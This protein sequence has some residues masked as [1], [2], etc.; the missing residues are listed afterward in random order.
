MKR[1]S[2]L[3]MLL[4]A[5]CVPLAMNAQTKSLKK[6]AKGLPKFEV[7][8]PAKAMPSNPM[9]SKLESAKEAAL[10]ELNGRGVRADNELLTEGF[11]N[12]SSISTTYSA[13]G[14]YAYNAGSGNNWTLNSTSTYANNGSKSAQV[15]YSSSYA[16]NCYLVSAPF[17]VSS[18]M[19]EL[20]VSL[21]ERVR[22]ASYAEI[23]EVFFV[24]ANDVTSAAGVASATKYNAIASASYTNTTYAQQSGTVTNSALAGQS[25]RVVVHCTSEADKY[26]LYIDDITVTEKTVVE[27]CS[28]PT[29]FAATNV[30]TNSVTLSWT[31]TGTSDTWV[32]YYM[33]E[34]DETTS[35]EIAE[36]NPFTLTG[37]NPVTN[38]YALV[39][40][41]CGDL[42]Q[43]SDVIEFTTQDLPCSKPTDL[44]VTA[45]TPSSATVSWSGE[46]DSYTI[47]YRVPS[48]FRYD[49]ESATAF[50]V[51]DFSPCTTYDG[52]GYGTYTIQN[53]TFDN[54][55]YTGSF[56]N[57]Q[58]G[59][60]SGLSA[61]GGNS[62]G[63]CFAAT[64]A[65]NNDWFILPAITI[66][67]GDVFSF[68]AKEYTDSYPEAFKVG[69]YRGN[70]AFS[71]Y[72]AGS[73]SS[74]ITPTTTWT[75]YSYDLSA[76][77]GQTIQLAIQCVSNDAFIFCID[78]IFVG[79]PNGNDSW[80]V[81]LTDVS[82]PYTITGLQAETTYEWHVQGD[83]GADG[84]SL[85]SAI[86]TFTTPNACG[87]PSGLTTTDITGT[88]ATLSWAAALDE[89]NVT[90]TKGFVYDF[91][92]A[93]PWVVDSFDPCTTYDGD[94]TQ[95]YG[96]EDADVTNIPFTGACVAFQNGVSSNLAAHSG[97]AFGMMISPAS[98]TV[99]ANDWFILPEIAIE[100]GDVFSFWGREITTQ[101]GNEV[102][103]VGVYGSQG[104]FSSYLA[105]NVQVASTDWTEY[106]Y[107]LS[108]YAGQTIQLA[109]NYV[110]L[111]IFGFMFDDIFVGNPNWSTPVSVT[112]STYTLEGLSMNTNYVW[113]V[114]GVDC[115]GNGSTT[116]WSSASFTTLDGILVESITADDV[117]V[118]VD[119][120][121]SIT[122]LVVLP[123]DATNPAVTYTSN[124]ETIAT[125]ENGVVTGVAVGTTTITIAA[126]DGSGVTA[127]INVTVNGIDVTGITAENVTVVNGETATISYTV[128][129]TNATDASVTFTSANTAIATVDADGVVTGVSVGETTITITSVSNPEVTAEITVTVTSNPNAVQF[130]VNAPANAAPGDVITV[131]AVLN[132][133]TEGTYNGF[134]GLVLGLHFNT[135]AFAVYGNPVPGPVASASTLTMPSLPNEN[136]ETVNYSC[137]MTS[138]NPNTTTGLVFSMQFTVL[139]EVESGSYTFYVEP[140]AA[141]QFVYNP[142]SGA[143][144]IPYEYVPST[145][146]I[147][148][149]EQYTL[150]IT[151][152]TNNGG[153]Y[154]IASPIGT[155]NPTEV[156]NM[157]TPNDSDNNRTYDLYRF[158]QDPSDGLE[159]RNYRQGVFDLEVGKGYLYAHRTD[160]DLVFTG[161]AISESTYEVPLTKVAASAGLEFPDWNLVG[162]PFAE[163]AHI[164]EGHPFYTLDVSGAYTLVSDGSQT[165]ES[166]QGVFVVAGENEDH[167]TFVKGEPSAKSP[168]VTLNV[169]NGTE[170]G[171]IDR[172]IVCF[173]ETRQMPKFQF[174][175]NSTKVYIPM[176]GKEY[177][178][179]RG[180]EM[181]ELPVNFKA[182]SNGTYSLNFSSE[183]VEFAYLHLIDNKTGNDVDL[184][185][186]PSYSFE[187]KTTD[188]ESRFKL[189]FATGDNS[190]DDNFAFFSNGSFVINNEGEAEL[191]VIDVMGRIL[192]SETIN[193][194]TNVNVNGA[195]GVYMLRLINGDN[196]KVQKVVVK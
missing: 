115:D 160:V 103:N 192:S 17:T 82:S 177:A 183:I 101:Y 43:D 158:Q 181:G 31:E 39:T 145:V 32:I 61:H 45:M 178:L 127:T 144:P 99:S 30:T 10:E 139:T 168:K 116:D 170:S 154:L 140:T 56:I 92:S 93:E 27:G 83:C 125:V 53:V 80:D 44:N 109:I 20:T 98:S 91:E 89:Y 48:G 12:M 3:I 37:L 169:S 95:C 18:N 111:D 14:W 42:D 25:V 179:V 151:G 105:Q 34:D 187:S 143:T 190:N 185:K 5:L 52:D 54:Q 189:V 130:T 176:E 196:V 155:V 29:N 149:P 76:Y 159:W 146:N 134:T 133:P 96:F 104:S 35:Y 22:S 75:E 86:G 175:R 81:T 156:T 110:S 19:S 161:S 24:K 9:L 121:A 162:N 85:W 184:L 88:S 13:T 118:T 38:Y 69:I 191:Q 70:G 193:G 57:F 152:Y 108:A 4:V 28:A 132:A 65:P 23:F 74:S 100:S 72:L 114:Q 21:Y 129:P 120:T 2:L 33:A 164:A 119:G 77:A 90:Y 157:I 137:A 78:D 173:G 47:Q 51:D 122:N 136:H 150:H 102:I 40:P 73:A 148:V 126:T 58:S 188:Y 1:K 6:S 50:A 147:A 163:I 15:K 67:N 131:E 123:A 41:Y 16:A 26:Y 97:N 141:N 49:F 79:N 60:A 68:W 55:G 166:M 8:A 124:D 84:Q 186:T 107:D 66:N 195:A 171:V 128:A 46:A 172:A 106:S 167:I 174:D 87:A 94:Q 135:E 64:T 138:G 113:Q 153:Y 62:F 11:E 71:S 142:D 182:E 36:T 117:T 59:I 63:A 112:G 194:C 7:N 165:I 180:E